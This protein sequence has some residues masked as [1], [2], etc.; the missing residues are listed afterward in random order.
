MSFTYQINDAKISLRQEKISAFNELMILFRRLLRVGFRFLFFS[1]AFAITWIVF[2]LYM[3]GTV[4]AD[5]IALG[6]IFA[7][8]GSAIVSVFTLFRN[9]QYSQFTDSTKILHEQLIGTTNWER[10]SFVKRVTKQKIS[11]KQYEFQTLENPTIVFS[12]SL[13]SVT[14]P[15][16][17]SK[18]DFYELPIYRSLIRLKRN[19]A[20]YRHILDSHQSPEAI[21]EILLWDCLTSIYKNIVLYRFGKS[22]T[23]L[24]GCFVFNSIFFSFFYS[25]LLN[26]LSC[27]L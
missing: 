15:L 21:K 14:I 24:G 19:R 22:L 2:N 5:T 23:W 4:W 13:W 9:E 27:Y 8:L 1:L 17:A 3:D 7:T 25:F 11:P 20:I 16:P 10:W 12:G 6:A 18:T 26:V